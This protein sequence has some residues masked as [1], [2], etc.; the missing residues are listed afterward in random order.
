MKRTKIVATVGPATADRATMA[1][2]VRAGANAFRINLSHGNPEQWAGL[3]DSLK[4]AAPDCPIIVDTE[5]PEIRIVNIPKPIEL[6]SG[7]SFT[8]S[9][10]PHA[11]LPHATHSVPLTKGQAVLLDDGAIRL[12]VDHVDGHTITSTAQTEGVLTDRRKLTVPSDMID[13]PVLSE[14]ACAFP[15]RAWSRR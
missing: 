7:Q 6:K 2:L 11:H 4:A 15:K 1:A 9:T 8:F 3:I 5:G 10:S 14:S 13:L 12:I